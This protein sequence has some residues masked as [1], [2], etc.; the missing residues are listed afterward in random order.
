MNRIKVYSLILVILTT[1]GCASYRTNTNIDFDS[2][3]AL[4]LPSDFLILE[5]DLLDTPYTAVAP[6]EAVVKK[7]TAFHKDPTKEQVNLVLFQQAA[8]LGGDAVINVKYKS[9]VGFGT[10]GYL[11]ANG[12]AVRTQRDAGGGEKAKAELQANTQFMGIAA[13]EIAS[14]TYD[15][16]LWVKALSLAEGDVEKQKGIYINLRSNQLASQTS[17]LEEKAKSEERSTPYFN[18]SGTYSSNITTDKSWALKKE[19][20]RKTTMT[21]MQFGSKVTGTDLANTLKISGTIER[22]TINFYMLPNNANSFNELNGIWKIKTDGT[23]LDGKWTIDG[24]GGA[25]GTWNLRKIK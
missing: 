4:E 10:W 18:V 8:S 25:S 2:T 21:L 7:L 20:Y 1:T 12:I 13:E 16:V 6:V 22:D 17:K 11:Q 19:S 15:K 3:E 23:G 24:F 5:G 9:G 14:K